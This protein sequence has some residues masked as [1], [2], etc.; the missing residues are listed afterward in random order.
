MGRASTGTTKYF[1]LSAAP[2][3]NCLPVATTSFA[4]AHSLPSDPLESGRKSKQQVDN[5]FAHPFPVFQKAHF[6]IIPI[7][8]IWLLSSSGS[9]L[10]LVRTAHHSPHSPHR[11][12]C[13]LS[14]RRG[15]ATEI[16]LSRCHREDTVLCSSLIPLL[17]HFLMFLATLFLCVE[18]YEYHEHTGVDAILPQ[19]NRPSVGSHFQLLRAL[20]FLLSRRPCHL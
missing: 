2:R 3:I 16:R 5:S 20:P 10:T 4:P 11:K 7:C 14:A 12:S 13:L 15:C 18:L 17:L 19:P 6:P 1:P 8:P 9:S